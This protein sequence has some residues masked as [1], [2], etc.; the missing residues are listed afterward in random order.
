[1]RLVVAAEP[2]TESELAVTLCLL[3]AAGIPATVS[4][5]FGGVL[6]GPQI[7]FHTA[8]RVLV[9]SAC[10]EEAEAAL[11]TIRPPLP[12]RT[13]ARDRLRI[14]LEFALFMWF[15]PGNRYRSDEHDNDAVDVGAPLNPD[16][17]AP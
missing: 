16:E 7:P 9:P 8:R 3:E 5:G 15:I 14:V 2:Q 11:R 6:P 10:L 12:D 4:A 1:M 13:R 17:Q